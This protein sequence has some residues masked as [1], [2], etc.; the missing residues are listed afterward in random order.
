M[1]YVDP[2]CRHGWTMY[3]KPVLSCHLFTDGLVEDLHRFAVR[4]DL[5]RSWFQPGHH[6]PH[7]DLTRRYRLAAIAAGAMPLSF[8]RSVAIWKVWKEGRH[9]CAGE[10]IETASPVPTDRRANV[11]HP[12]KAARRR[13]T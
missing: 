4:I 3:G 2:L 12:A 6:V 5:R 1:I 8:R 11:H 10:R 9:R 7:Y 13:G